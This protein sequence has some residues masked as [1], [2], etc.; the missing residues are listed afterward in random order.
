M[1]NL[2]HLNSPYFCPFKIQLRLYTNPTCTYYI[3]PFIDGATVIS[4]RDI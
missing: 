2:F 4:A 3:C 1:K